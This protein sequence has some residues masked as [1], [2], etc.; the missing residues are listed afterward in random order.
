MQPLSLARCKANFFK[1]HFDMHKSLSPFTHIPSARRW[2]NNSL[3]VFFSSAANAKYLLHTFRK[4]MG[5]HLVACFFNDTLP[6]SQDFPFTICRTE[7]ISV[8]DPFREEKGVRKKASKS[9]SKLRALIC[10][11][12][13][14]WSLPHFSWFSTIT[15]KTDFLCMLWTP[16]FGW[17][18]ADIKQNICL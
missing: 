9:W 1:R 3:H 17:N 5:T 10:F 2:A 16:K 8:L 11:C 6:I 13:N 15:C 14:C 18:G 4:R 12:F 7:Q